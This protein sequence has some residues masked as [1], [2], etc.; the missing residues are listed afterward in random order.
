MLQHLPPH[1]PAVSPTIKH[2]NNLLTRSNP[3]PSQELKLLQ[4]L[5]HEIRTP[6]TSIRTLIRSLIKRYPLPAKVMQRLHSIDQECT[7]QIERME[8]IFKATELESNKTQTPGTQLTPISLQIMFET[9]IPRWQQQ[10]QRRNINLDVLMPQHLPQV[11]ITE[12]AL[13]D[14]MLTGLIE[15]FTRNLTTGDRIQLHIST[16]GNQLKLQLLPQ[17][18]HHH[19]FEALGQLLTF[20]PTTGN[21]SLNLDVTKNLCQA[22]GGKLIVKNKPTQGESFTI[23]LPLGNR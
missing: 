13:L 14:R 11:V 19:R 20:Q 10:A 5:T 6:L 23:F 4:V 9:N 2:Q 1:K 12:P 7:E 8:L 16:A 15:K 22:L 21:V 17:A 18:N 3:D